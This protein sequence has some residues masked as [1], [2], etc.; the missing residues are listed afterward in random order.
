MRLHQLGCTL[1]GAPPPRGDQIPS[2]MGIDSTVTDQLALIIPEMIEALTQRVREGKELAV[3]RDPR[4]PPPE[5]T[6]YHENPDDDEPPAKTYTTYEFP[7]DKLLT[8]QPRAH[9]PDPKHTSRSP[10]H[11]L[12]LTTVQTP[13]RGQ[14][15]TIDIPMRPPPTPPTLHSH[16]LDIP[17]SRNRKVI[18]RRT[19]PSNSRARDNVSFFSI[20]SGLVKGWFGCR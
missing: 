8:R 11:R 7:F 5:Q 10:L 20:S 2:D 19:C 1:H 9:T 3:Q 12:Q 13:V 14:T 18:H 17:T 15:L 16:H 4:P 6:R